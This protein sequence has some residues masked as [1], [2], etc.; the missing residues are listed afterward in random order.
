MFVCIDF[1][2]GVAIGH[3]LGG[4]PATMLVARFFTILFFSP[5]LLLK[6]YCGSGGWVPSDYYVYPQP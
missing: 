3:R 5:L 1:W 6:V 4:Q 2:H